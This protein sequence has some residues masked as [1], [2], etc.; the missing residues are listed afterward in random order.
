MVK[1]VA[2][3]LK[4]QLPLLGAGSTGDDSGPIDHVD[5]PADAG[6]LNCNWYMARASNYPN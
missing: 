1:A 3:V 5:K 4:D 6:K 2:K